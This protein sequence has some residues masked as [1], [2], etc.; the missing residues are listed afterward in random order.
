MK[1]VFTATLLFTEA[2]CWLGVARLLLVFMPFRKIVPLLGDSIPA[3]PTAPVTKTIR[4]QRIRAAI[5]RA[6]AC[7]PWRTKCFEQALAGKLMLRYRK[8]PGVV[9]F[10]VNKNGNK[11]NAHAWLECNGIIVTGHTGIDEY[12]VIARFKS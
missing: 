7:A 10:G 9:F 3:D 2:W 12:T 4:P 5:R 6:A 1:K 8:L 11:M